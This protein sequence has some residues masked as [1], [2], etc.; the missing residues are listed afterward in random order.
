MSAEGD[1]YYELFE[2]RAGRFWHLIVSGTRN[3]LAGGQFG[4]TLASC[5]AGS[6]DEMD[7]VTVGAVLLAV[8]SGEI[9]SLLSG[10][11]PRRRGHCAGITL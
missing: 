5:D 7:P 10:V 9:V 4:A 1:G 3:E 11:G 6:G 2:M 8:A